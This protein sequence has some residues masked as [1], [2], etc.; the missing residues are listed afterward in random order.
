MRALFP[1]STL[2]GLGLSLVA[3]ALCALATALVVLPQ[4]LAQSPGSDGVLAVH[5]D[6]RGTLRLW[7]RPIPA[8]ELLELLHARAGHNTQSSAPGSDGG[9]RNLTEGAVL[10]LIPDP[11]VPWGVVRQVAAGLEGT[12]LPL[13]LQLP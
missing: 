8:G 2:D 12:G 5:L 13:E 7:N 3:A 6:S 4:R 11:G 10:R 9:G 1:R